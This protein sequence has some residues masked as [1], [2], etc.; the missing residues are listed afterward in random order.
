MCPANH[1]AYCESRQQLIDTRQSLGDCIVE[2]QCFSDDPCPLFV[3]FQAETGC[4][5]AVRLRGLTAQ[6]VPQSSLPRAKSDEVESL[7]A[8]WHGRRQPVTV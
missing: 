6:E 5:A 1:Q 2:H 8:D 7:G 4:T 3:K